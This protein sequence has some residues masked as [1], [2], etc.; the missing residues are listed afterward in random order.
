MDGRRR[1]SG[2]EGEGRGE[3]R[4]GEG[5]GKE[6]RESKFLSKE[7]VKMVINSEGDVGYCDF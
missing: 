7:E 4:K 1:G 3:G 5:R 2:R 6:K